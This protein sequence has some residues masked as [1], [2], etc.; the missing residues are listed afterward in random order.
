M[1]ID[2]Y[3]TKGIVGTAA[4]NTGFADARRAVEQLNGLSEL[5]KLFEDGITENPKQAANDAFT[6]AHKVQE[7]DVRKTLVIISRLLKK[8]KLVGIVQT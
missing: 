4:T 6:A 5:K 7:N 3:D 8:S 2:I 1:S